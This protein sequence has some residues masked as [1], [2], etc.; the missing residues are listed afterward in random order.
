MKHILALIACC[1][2]VVPALAQ[3]NLLP[4]DPNTNKV[5]YAE[6]VTVSGQS[7]AK[8]FGKAMKWMG[9]KHTEVN[10]YVVTYENEAEGTITGK[11]SFTLPAERRKYNVQFLV[12][13]S[14]KDGRYKYELTD[15]M[16][17]FKTAAGASGGGFGYW[18]SS[19]YKEAEMTQYSLETFYP[20]RLKNKN[21]P[22]IKYFEEINRE[23]FEAIDREMRSLAGS[24]KETLA[25][26]NDW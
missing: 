6:V 16:I 2:L 18:S 20:A 7:K 10:P 11:G 3:D 12:N 4:I 8:V 21:K 23:S 26:D 22:V 25:K 5:S 14:I 1:W 24:L 9:T 17:Q 19:S 15:I 13:I